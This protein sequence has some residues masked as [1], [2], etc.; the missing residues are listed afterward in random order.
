MLYT[1]HPSIRFDNGC[2]VAATSPLAPHQGHEA[3]LAQAERQAAKSNVVARFRAVRF[4]SARPRW[5][6]ETRLESRRKW[7]IYRS[8]E[9]Y[10]GLRMVW[11]VVDGSFTM[12]FDWF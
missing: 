11:F 10:S 7:E 1:S 12:V 9:F 3:L 8:P 2:F 4:D 5:Q 6:K